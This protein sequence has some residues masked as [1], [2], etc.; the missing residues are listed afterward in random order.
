[1][2]VARGFVPLILH[3]HWQNNSPAET[4]VEIGAQAFRIEGAERT[5]RLVIVCDHASNAVPPEIGGGSLGLPETEMSRHIAHDVGAA[6]VA[7]ALGRL[8]DSPVIEATFS[9]LVIDPNRG[10]DDPTLVMRLYD[11]TIIPG[12]RHIDEAEIARR[13]DLHYRPYH[14]ALAGLLAARAGAVPVSIHSFTPRLSGRDPRPWHVGVLHGD[15][16]RL[17]APMLAR[18]A[19]EPDIMPGDNEPYAGFFE[20]DTMYRH[21]IRAGRPY[22]LLEIRN[23]LIAD[24]AG[25]KAW[26]ARLA[27]MIAEVVAGA[28]P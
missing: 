4:D 27:P 11:G 9:R 28:L 3:R 12:N 1:M 10:E 13:R 21:A 17:A 15:D 26:A 19:A 25:Q 6:G 7:R 23:D 14:A 8:L 22:L 20:G 16:M 5:G 24:T 2:L 18:L